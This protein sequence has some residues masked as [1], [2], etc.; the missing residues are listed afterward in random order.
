MFYGNCACQKKKRKKKK[1]KRKK[2]IEKRKKR[3]KKK[4]KKK[5]KKK[6]GNIGK[7]MERVRCVSKHKADV[8]W[9]ITF[10]A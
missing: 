5:K 8:R 2:E 9:H 1:K 10:R 3:K 6:I 4:R 7:Q